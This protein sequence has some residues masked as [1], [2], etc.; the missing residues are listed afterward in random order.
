MPLAIYTAFNGSGVTTD[1][2]VALSLLLIAVAV[3]I[4]VLVGTRRASVLS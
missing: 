3:I 2:A 4:L 1:Q